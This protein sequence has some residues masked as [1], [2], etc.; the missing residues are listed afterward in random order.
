[1]SMTSGHASQP[2]SGSGHGI[3]Q[4]LLALVL[5]YE[6]GKGGLPV[7]ITVV[8][9]RALY[10]VR[11][12]KAQETASQQAIDVR[13]AAYWFEPHTIPFVAAYH[14]TSGTRLSLKLESIC[15]RRKTHQP[16][17]LDSGK[18]IVCPALAEEESA[19]KAVSACCLSYSRCWLRRDR[20]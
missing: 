20:P 7:R 15:M 9:R 3:S 10:C 6:L 13:P 8:I 4:H 17:Q 5:E 2:I 18:L 16:A 11:S 1:M 19:I 14:S 12:V